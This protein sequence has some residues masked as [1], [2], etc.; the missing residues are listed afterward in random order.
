MKDLNMR[1]IEFLVNSLIVTLNAIVTILLTAF[2]KALATLI[3]IFKEFE[4]MFAYYAEQR[5]KAPTAFLKTAIASLVVGVSYVMTIVVFSPVVFAGSV[6]V[7]TVE[8]F[9]KSKVSEQVA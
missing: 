4:F 1:F 8:Y 9:Q 3:D 7:S 2:G 6:I 5:Q